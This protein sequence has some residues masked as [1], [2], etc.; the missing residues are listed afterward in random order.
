M[1]VF[2]GAATVYYLIRRIWAVRE[3]ALQQPA[4]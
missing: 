1:A 3:S 4:P 2:I